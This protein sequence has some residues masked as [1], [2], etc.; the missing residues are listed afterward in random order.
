[1]KQMAPEVVVDP[2]HIIIADV[3][4]RSQESISDESLANLAK[5]MEQRG[6][7]HPVVVRADHTGVDRYVL[8]A[9]KRRT[10]AAKAHGL[11]VRACVID[12]TPSGRVQLALI[13]NLQREDMNALDTARALQDALAKDED[14]DQQSLA[15]LIGVSS[16]FVSQHLALLDL[17]DRARVLIRENKIGFAH[18]RQL[19]RLK[20]HP[21]LLESLLDGVENMTAS[22][23][24]S[25]VS[26][27]LETLKEHAPRKA[28]ADD[29]TDENTAEDA[30]AS[31]ADR[32][33]KAKFKL[34]SEKSLRSIMLSYAG[35]LARARTFESK[36]EYQ[37]ILKGLEIAAGLTK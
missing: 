16:P 35:K 23:L 21:E 8:I 10:L 36:Q 2:E 20:D 33:R 15:R 29:A 31:V 14:L 18:G 13:E 25:R 34:R 11:K 5:S 7:L 22:E 24:E 28:P 32:Y 26:H 3:D 17:P 19:I 37:G 12:D 6:Q 27:H 9:G 1:M 30:E 4:I